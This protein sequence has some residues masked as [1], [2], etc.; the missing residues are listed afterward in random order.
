MCTFSAP[1]FK[2]YLFLCC[3]KNSLPKA[4]P[5]RQPAKRTKKPAK[6]AVESADEDIEIDEESDGE[7]MFAAT[8]PSKQ[9]RNGEKTMYNF[10]FNKK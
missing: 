8:P 7:D 1:D 4:S 10:C 5:A 2:N 9:A 3:R 6:S